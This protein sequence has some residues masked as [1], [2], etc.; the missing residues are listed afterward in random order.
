MRDVKIENLKEEKGSALL[1]V[2]V[3]TVVFMIML[4][5][6]VSQ[7]LFNWKVYSFVKG[8][9][10]SQQMV[11]DIAAIL[12]FEEM[13]EVT[14]KDAD[15]S[16]IKD[17]WENA[18]MAKVMKYV[19]SDTG[20]AYNFLRYY[21]MPDLNSLVSVGITPNEIML[22]KGAFFLDANCTASLDIP[23][24]HDIR[25][26]AVTSY[27]GNTVDN[28]YNEL[29]SEYNKTSNVT[30]DKFYQVVSDVAF[31]ISW[32]NTESIVMATGNAKEWGEQLRVKGDVWEKP[33]NDSTVVNFRPVRT[34]LSSWQV[35]SSGEELLAQ[36][37]LYLR[38]HRE[39][40]HLMDS[41][42]AYGQYHY[43]GSYFSVD[44][45]LFG[46]GPKDNSSKV[47]PSS[48]SLWVD[49]NEG[50]KYITIYD[51]SAG[52]FRRY[53]LVSLTR[54]SVKDQDDYY[55]Y[56]CSILKK[57][58][59]EFYFEP[60][61]C[62]NVY[63]FNRAI[64][65]DAEDRVCV[66]VKYGRSWPIDC[67][68]SAYYYVN[69]W[70]VYLGEKF[71][72]E[73]NDPWNNNEKD[74]YILLG[75]PWYRF[76][77]SANWKTDSDNEIVPGK[78]DF[79]YWEYHAVNS[80]LMSP[81]DLSNNDV[82]LGNF[83]TDILLTEG[84][85]VSDNRLFE[86]F[87]TN[88][89]WD[90]LI[91][92]SDLAPAKR[93]EV[94]GDKITV[95]TTNSY[96]LTLYT[97]DEGGELHT[98][99]RY[100]PGSCEYK[101]G[102]ELTGDSNDI[103]LQV[104]SSTGKGI[105]VDFGDDADLYLVTPCQP[106]YDTWL[107]IWDD[108][109]HIAYSGNSILPSSSDSVED[110][111]AFDG[112]YWRY[113]Y[114][115]QYEDLYS[116]TD[117]VTV[118]G[119]KIKE[120]SLNNNIDKSKVYIYKRVKYRVCGLFLCWDEWR[121]EE[122][123]VFSEIENHL[124]QDVKNWIINGVNDF[125]E[126][127]I[128][129]IKEYLAYYPDSFLLY[130]DDSINPLVSDTSY[131]PNWDYEWTRFVPITEEGFENYFGSYSKNSVEAKIYHPNW[132]NMVQ[133]NFKITI[134][135]KRM[136]VLGDVIPVP[137][138]IGEDKMPVY[139]V[140]LR[141]DSNPAKNDD[142]PNLSKIPYG[143]R[144]GFLLK[145]CKDSSYKLETGES[146]PDSDAGVCSGYSFWLWDK[147]GLINYENSDV[148]ENQYYDFLSKG[149]KYGFRFARDGNV[150]IGKDI[151]NGNMDLDDTDSYNP[152]KWEL[153][154]WDKLLYADIYVKN[155]GVGVIY[156]ARYADRDLLDD[157][158][159]YPDGSGDDEGY[160]YPIN[161]ET[162]RLLGSMMMWGGRDMYEG[163]SF[164]LGGYMHTLSDPGWGFSS[165]IYY[166]PDNTFSNKNPYWLISEDEQIVDVNVS[167]IRMRR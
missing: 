155:G 5:I 144:L 45:I 93:A 162:F 34:A 165:P 100:A 107:P 132:K 147:I 118:N 51:S 59:G 161:S 25:I 14:D 89:T 50:K 143:E 125:V 36:S 60:C 24:D 27:L 119:K 31:H 128:E 139:E 7:V 22:P 97:K 73:K 53:A 75:M 90:S 16:Y 26:V 159:T 112:T 96:V 137:G 37:D 65:A 87:F 2:L 130:P 29:V 67:K 15:W 163:V 18:N 56:V 80:Q 103:D 98:I 154:S 55:H 49:T 109:C 6:L 149:N 41:V 152:Y 167:D 78:V 46:K 63:P 21:P 136:S 77:S 113:Y 121:W 108:L 84:F 148:P 32:K 44:G 120:L 82:T 142:I 69:G 124:P 111:K 140:D 64:T 127:K 70:D 99:L 129:E 71:P 13:N 115:F 91:E 33:A 156:L 83:Y 35:F 38:K 166:L 117:I 17:V 10:L 43:G 158:D 61:S 72:W 122:Q 58:M 76:V 47:I 86:T 85:S 160:K 9:F 54:K 62:P 102:C 164:Y 157:A 74:K 88:H 101:H 57:G 123:G 66:A 12:R 48:G 19:P 134:V 3:F 81:Q 95:N 79:L 11:S 40:D 92:N 135:G 68:Q 116:T 153:R 133:Y 104:T 20:D 146:T 114:K 52:K 126:E 138:N 23:S 42:I 39:G 30:A 131:N 105:L 1:L 94:N 141:L 110:T 8:K 150:Y 145:G 4:S 151:T 28:I 106:G